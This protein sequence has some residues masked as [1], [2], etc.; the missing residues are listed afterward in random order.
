VIIHIHNMA[1][2]RLQ[3]K[4]ATSLSPADAQQEYDLRKTV[5]A[6]TLPAS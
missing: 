4:L 2:W 3:I 1:A 6:H 5:P